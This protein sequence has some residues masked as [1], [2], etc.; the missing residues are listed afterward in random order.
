VLVVVLAVAGFL[1]WRSIKKIIKDTV[2]TKI[3]ELA[4][5][6]R[7]KI[8]TLIKG[9]VS[10]ITKEEADKLFYDSNMTASINE[11]QEM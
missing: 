2:A 5:A 9:E 10:K 7:E 1:T 6:E 4:N 8:K 3:N 11:K